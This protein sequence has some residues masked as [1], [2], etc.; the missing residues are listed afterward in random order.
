MDL[1]LGQHAVRVGRAAGGA[2]G[3]RSRGKS[4]LKNVASHFSN[5]VAAGQHVVGQPGRL[6]EG[7]VDHHEGVERRQR[8]AHA[9]AVG[10]R[11]GRVGALDEHGPVAGGMVG[12]DL[13]GDDVARHEA[14]DDAG[15]D[16]RAAPLAPARRARR[17]VGP[18]DGH[19][20][21]RH[22]LGPPVAEVAGQRPD[23]LLEVADQR[24]VQAHLHA[25]VLEHGHALGRRRCGGRLV[26]R[27]PR[28]R[29]RSRR[30]R[31]RRPRRA[32]SPTSS[33]PVACSASHA[34]AMSPSCTT[35]APSAASSHASVPGRTCRW[36]SASA[37]VSVRRGSITIMD[38]AGSLAI[39][40]M[41]RAGPRDAV[42]LPR[43]LADEQR[44]LAV[45]EVGPDHGAEHLGVD[46]ELAGLLLGQRVRAVPRAEGPQGGPA[47]GAARGGSPGRRRRSRRSTRRRARRGPRRAAR[48]PRR[49]RCPSRSPRTCRRHAA[50]AA[51]SAAR[52]RSGS[53]RGAA[54]SR[55]CSPSRPGGPCRRGCARS[56]GR[57]HRRGAPRCRSCTRTGCRP[58]T[59]RARGRSWSSWPPHGRFDRCQF[60]R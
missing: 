59:A 11:V 33:A 38:R 42:A 55:T 50:A 15:A 29:R 39:S 32:P 6:G 28:R 30:T 52:R 9:P 60:D 36:K 40:L 49:W 35:T 56:G 14:G 20:A 46:P 54:P 48:R 31:R 5:W 7:D 4:K 34:R 10:Q 51:R 57:R 1:G 23:Q 44:D 45:L 13:V 22:V 47:V 53:G 21:R 17:L 18:G 58:S 25:E 37:A 3:T 43:V 41:R 16:D 2:G 24:G 19:E 27:G 8:L 12:E 26:G